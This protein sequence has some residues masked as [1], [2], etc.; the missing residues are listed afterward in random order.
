MAAGAIA[1]SLTACAAGDAAA[2]TDRAAG[3]DY[4]DI[5]VQLSWLK[6]HEFSGYYE[7]IEGGYFDEAGFGEVDLVA[8]GIG[9]VPAATALTSGTAWV[10]I[11]APADIAQANAEGAD[12]RIV[13]T[14]YQKNPFTLV[15]ADS[16]PITEPSDLVGKTIAI[17][18]SSATNWEAFLAANDID[19]S[20]VNRVPYGDAQTDLKLGSIDGFMGYGDGGAA[21]RA[22]G[23]G[24]QEFLLADHGL[25]YSGEAVVV[26]A[27]TLAE[28]PDKVEAFLTAYA[29]G[30]KAA[31]DDVD[32]TIDL[33]VDVYG[34][35]QNYDRDSIALSWDQQAKLILTDESRELGIGIVTDEAVQ[36]NVDSLALAGYDVEADSLF[37]TSLI[38]KVYEAHPELVLG[39]EGQ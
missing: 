37:D 15:S 38:A 18:D 24:A 26:T 14:T 11:A 4:G 9:G 12:L 19:P 3:A 7:A 22:S 36:R 31:F 28:E 35:D 10:G 13:A 29:Q 30:W 39:T 25:A 5:T 33:V 6:N 16:D 20:E 27:K 34:K 2:E 23:F 32:G 17:A 21:L 1:L 8:G